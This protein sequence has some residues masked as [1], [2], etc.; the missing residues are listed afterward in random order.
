MLP[1]GYA[2]TLHQRYPAYVIECEGSSIAMDDEIVANI[3]VWQ[4][5][6]HGQATDT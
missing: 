4:T 1:M 2:P 5:P 3:H 6:D